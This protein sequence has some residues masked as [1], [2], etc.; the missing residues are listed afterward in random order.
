MIANLKEGLNYKYIKH[1]FINGDITNLSVYEN[2][3]WENYQDFVDKN[4]VI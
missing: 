2:W 4:Y 3:V 1:H